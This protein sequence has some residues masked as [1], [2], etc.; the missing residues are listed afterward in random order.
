MGGGEILALHI[1]FCRQ[2]EAGAERSRTKEKGGVVPTPP[3]AEGRSRLL[4]VET[5]A[6]RGLIAA[7]AVSAGVIGIVIEVSNHRS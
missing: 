5:C 2:F 6:D 4:E 1:G 3:A 7:V